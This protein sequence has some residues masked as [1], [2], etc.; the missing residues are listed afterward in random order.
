MKFDQANEK[1]VTAY[2]QQYSLGEQERL[3]DIVYKHPMQL[4]IIFIYTLV[5]FGAVLASTG[6]L[7]AQFFGDDTASG[8][9]IVNFVG[10]IAG[11]ITGLILVIATFLFRQTKLLISNENL[12]QILQKD[13]LHNKTSRLALT[14]IEDI[15]S[16]QHGFL[17]TLFGYGNLVI[18]TAGEQVNFIFTFCPDPNRIAKE[19]ID[20]KEVLVNSSA[21]YE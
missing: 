4:I 12:I 11:M 16:E 5:G 2:R 14:D 9:R 21:I 15:T 19:L 20:A 1:Q 3:L 8:Y 6:F 17:S 10:I 18:E 13:L 7:A